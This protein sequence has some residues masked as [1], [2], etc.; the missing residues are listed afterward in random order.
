MV[1]GDSAGGVDE[2]AQLGQDVGV[3]SPVTAAGGD[4][5]LDVLALGQA[6]KGDDA[7][8]RR[9]VEGGQDAA[10]LAA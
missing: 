8:P 4:E 10:T 2:G 3:A 6:R 7:D 9:R 1:P 5:L